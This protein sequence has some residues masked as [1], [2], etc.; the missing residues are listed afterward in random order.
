MALIAP[1]LLKILVCPISRQPLV[2][3]EAKGVLRCEANG[4]EYPVRDGIPIMLVEEESDET[5]GETSEAWQE[6]SV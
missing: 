6:K 4:R 2:E 1:E 5:A 3:D